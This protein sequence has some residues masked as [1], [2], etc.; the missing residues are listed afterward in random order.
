MNSKIK[1]GEV[2]RGKELDFVKELYKE[3]KRSEKKGLASKLMR[4]LFMTEWDSLVD[5]S[6]ELGLHKLYYSK[7]E[8]ENE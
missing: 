3:C 6:D 4:E 5:W 2:A 8:N 7:G 1:D